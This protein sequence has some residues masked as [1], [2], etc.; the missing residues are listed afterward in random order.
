MNIENRPIRVENTD[1]LKGEDLKVPITHFISEIFQKQ[2]NPDRNMDKDYDFL[3]DLHISY[4]GSPKAL[5]VIKKGRAKI[6]KIDFE[7][8]GEKLIKIEVFFDT[9]DSGENITLVQLMN[10]ALKD[11]LKKNNLETN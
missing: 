2:D 1:K 6:E 9:E 7:M 3:T 4:N 11:F 10:R 8:Q 5:E